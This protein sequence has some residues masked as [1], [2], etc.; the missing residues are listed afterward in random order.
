MTTLPFSEHVVKVD[1][2][3]NVA[4]VKFGLDAGVRL[5]R[6]RDPELCVT[7]AV[8]AGNRVALC[9]IPVP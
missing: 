1:P 4:V 2:A 8:T 9:D 7:A 3:D 5:V 6:E